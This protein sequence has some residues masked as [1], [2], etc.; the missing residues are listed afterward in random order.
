MATMTGKISELVGGYNVTFEDTPTPKIVKKLHYK[1]QKL[2]EIF[3]LHYQKKVSPLMNLNNCVNILFIFYTISSHPA[4][5]GSQ[6][7]IISS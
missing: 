3:I 2:L 6:S 1:E 4:K 7:L 5:L